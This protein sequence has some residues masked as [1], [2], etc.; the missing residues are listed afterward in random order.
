MFNFQWK[1]RRKKSAKKNPINNFP[2]RTWKKYFCC[3][4]CTRLNCM[5]RSNQHKY[6]MVYIRIGNYNCRH[7]TWE[8]SRK[9]CTHFNVLVSKQILT[10]FY[11]FHLPVLLVV[12]LYC[13]R[14]N[15]YFIYKWCFLSVRLKL[16]LTCSP[17]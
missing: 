2:W 13:E 15:K 5:R 3:M 4:I 12:A 6:Q 17:G 8:K 9:L 11:C 1:R 16:C 10:S 14:Q 7:N